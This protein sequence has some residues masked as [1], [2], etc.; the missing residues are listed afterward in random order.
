VVS[1]TTMTDVMLC[2]LVRGFVVVGL[3]QYSASHYSEV[4]VLAFI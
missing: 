4:I 3:Q 1:S 2:N